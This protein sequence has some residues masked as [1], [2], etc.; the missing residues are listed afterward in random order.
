MG[1]EDDDDGS[2]TNLSAVG[3]NGGYGWSNGRD[4]SKSGNA[5]E[6]SIKYY[7]FRLQ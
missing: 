7:W 2:P 5:S 6:S 4:S 3:L 1:S